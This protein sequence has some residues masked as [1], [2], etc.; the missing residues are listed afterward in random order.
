MH[1]NLQSLVLKIQRISGAF[2]RALSAQN[3]AEFVDVFHWEV[4]TVTIKLYIRFRAILKL[5]YKDKLH[6]IHVL[7]SGEESA[8]LDLEIY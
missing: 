7:Y 3:A 1:S 6:L 8:H 5:L 4:P 2:A